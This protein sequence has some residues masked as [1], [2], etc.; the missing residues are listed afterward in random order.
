MGSLQMII[1]STLM[2]LA[3]LFANGGPE[4][5]VFAIAACATATLLVTWLTLKHA[6]PAE[7]MA[8]AE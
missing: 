1:G 5:M 3:G 6:D 4:P 7:S 2:A 8:I